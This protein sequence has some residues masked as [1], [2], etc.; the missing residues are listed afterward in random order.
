MKRSL[1]P[2]AL[3]VILGVGA[4]LWAVGDVQASKPAGSCHPAWKCASSAPATPRTTITPTVAPTFTAVPTSA[5][6]ASSY[7]FD[8]EFSGTALGPAWHHNFHCCGV[9]T[10]DP[11]LSSV[12]GDGYLHLSVVSRAGTWYGT[13]VDTKGSFEQTYGYFEARIAIPKGTGLWPASWLY[14]DG[15]DEIDTMEVCANPLGA[16]GGNDAS[17]LHTTVHAGSQGNALGSAIVAGDL[18]S[19]FHTY[20]VDWRPTAIAFYLDG[21]QVWRETSLLVATPKAVLLNLGLG[22]S[23]C[24]N[25]TTSTPPTSEMLVDWVRVEP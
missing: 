2:F 16:N 19:G 6:T 23:W 24:G 13:I 25:P 14:R 17:V 18:T 22:G 9:V 20:G 10:M 5:P 21:I 4:T 7:T 8:D 3:G 11:S 15:G 12:P 1:L